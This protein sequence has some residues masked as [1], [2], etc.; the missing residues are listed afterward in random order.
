L[1]YLL[2]EMMVSRIVAAL[3]GVHNSVI[4]YDQRFQAVGSQRLIRLPTIGRGRI[5]P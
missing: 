3:V 2:L 1:E 4:E 5:L